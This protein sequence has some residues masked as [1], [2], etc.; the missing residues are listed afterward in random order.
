MSASLADYI[1]A[2]QAAQA[3]AE[4]VRS[5]YEYIELLASNIESSSLHR[6]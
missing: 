4:K 1:E 3:A 6:E 2:N 5:E